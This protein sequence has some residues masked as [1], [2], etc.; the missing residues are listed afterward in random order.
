MKKL[1]NNWSLIEEYDGNYIFENSNKSFCVNV[2]F[3]TRCEYPYSISF[4]QIQGE[5]VVIGIENGAYATH[6]KASHEAFNKACEMM[7]FINSKTI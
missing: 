7:E 1:P 2:D 5:F 3:I 4:V 6:A